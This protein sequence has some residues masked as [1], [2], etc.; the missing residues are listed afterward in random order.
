[1]SIFQC[2]PNFSTCSKSV[3][4]EIK[5]AIECYADVRDFSFDTDHNRSV[6][7]FVGNAEEIK[8]AVLA[9]AKIA[10]EKIDLRS[11]KGVH[12]RI[13]AVDVIPVVP[14]FGSPMSE[15]VDL[16]YEIGYLI[17]GL[18][19]PVYF[20]ENSAK[21][22]EYTFLENIRK[23]GFEYLMKDSSCRVPD[24]GN[25]IHPNAGAVAIGA[26]Q[27]LVAYN[28]NLNTTDVEIAKK[29][30]GEIRVLR[31]SGDLKM[32]GIKAIGLLLKSSN[33]IQVS[34]NITRP[35]KTGVYEVFEYIS[36]RAKDFGTSVKN[37]EL[38]GVIPDSIASDIIKKA[39]KF[40]DFTPKRILFK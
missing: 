36:S 33:I 30:A 12:P 27:P 23:G 20:Y 25:K 13:G 29:I 4:T 1:M 32:E 34:T 18:G 22:K 37:S 2:I 28:V 3:I 31:K 24:I 8:S 10:I 39:L 6:I 38:I 40:D 15:A 11:H 35:A 5:K 26:R 19:L 16:S 7:T 14:V 17:S 9:S 21:N